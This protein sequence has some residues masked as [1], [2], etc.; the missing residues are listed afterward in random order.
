[1]FFGRVSPGIWGPDQRFRAI[2]GK[3]KITKTTSANDDKILTT[4][5][6]PNPWIIGFL[7]IIKSES[8]E[9]KI[10]LCETKCKLKRW[11]SGDRSEERRA[12]HNLLPGLNAIT[13]STPGKPDG[14]GRVIPDFI[15]F[16]VR[17]T[18]FL[19]RPG[20]PHWWGRSRRGCSSV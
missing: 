8:K 9:L 4:G 11:K 1:M 10:S 12:D 6:S 18:V 13:G 14:P 20:Y 7:G 19:P 5:H 17:P 3:G 2:G 15:L 16:L